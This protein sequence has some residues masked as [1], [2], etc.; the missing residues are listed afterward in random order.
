MKAFIFCILVMS[1]YGAWAGEVLVKYRSPSPALLQSQTQFSKVSSL[2]SYLAPYQ[3]LEKQEK[4]RLI[5]LRL[6][7]HN[8]EQTLKYLR[9]LSEVEYI[10]PNVIFKSYLREGGAASLQKQWALSKIRAQEAWK[11][12]GNYGS[13]HIKVAIIDSGVDYNH[14]NL[15]PNIVAGFDFQDN[16]ND[17]FDIVGAR[18]IGHGTHCAGVI[19]ATGLVEHGVVG[20][21][22]EVSIMPL[23]FLGE[24]GQGD[25]N[26]A[27]KAVDYAV[28][29]GAH[30]ISASWGAAVKREDVRPLLEAIKR[31][32]DRGVIFIAAAGNEGIN[33]DYTEIYPAASG[34]PNTITVN[35][36]D[37][38]DRRPSWSNHGSRYIHLAAPGENILSTLPDNS[39]GRLSGTSMSAPLVA[40][41]AAYLLA[42]DAS[43]TGA[44]IRALIQATGARASTSTACNCRLDALA[45]VEALI[46]KKIWTVPFAGTYSHGNSFSIQVVN[47][48][49][50]LTYTSSNTWVAKVSATGLVS[51][52]RPGGFYITVTDASGRSVRTQRFTV[53]RNTQAPTPPTPT[54]PPPQEP[55]P[56]PSPTP[57]EE[58]APTEPPPS[59]PL[60]QEPLPSPPSEQLP[61]K[62]PAPQEVCVLGDPLMC[63]VVC[64][65]QS[66]AS[67]CQ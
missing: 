36:T 32:D 55:T 16:D 31:A 64:A 15:A 1:H 61:Q 63:Q 26:T 57:P 41:F 46:E 12:A 21:S 59:E 47:A 3:I 39:Y 66:K 11:R 65:M 6:D 9:S 62:L 38:N 29:Q 35:A 2:N 50:P 17:P 23:R 43:L 25:L 53:L 52:E 56:S 34:Y 19:G 22:P 45:A 48:Q 58:P 33:T 13:R 4:A 27:V 30:V 10:V 44:Q 60:P 28:Q 67:V 40:G 5:K 51:L 37:E 20:I 8:Q 49:P 18:N 24:N 42:Q 54:P 7:D 14:S